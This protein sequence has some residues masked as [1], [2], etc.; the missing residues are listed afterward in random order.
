MQCNRIG[1][2]S[3]STS[4]ARSHRVATFVTQ[5]EFDTLRAFADENGKSISMLVYELLSLSLP[6]LKQ[7]QN[8]RT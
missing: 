8:P 2:P 5:G 3:L 1:R 4:R 7:A 6:E